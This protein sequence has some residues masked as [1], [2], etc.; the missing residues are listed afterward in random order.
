M[1]V[2]L[3]GRN[4]FI[5]HSL[6]YYLNKKLKIKIKDYKEIINKKV[7]FFNEFNYIINCA[8]NKSY[9]EKK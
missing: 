3:I 6:K 9:V 1:K 4:S 2:L 5:T 8:S 7:K